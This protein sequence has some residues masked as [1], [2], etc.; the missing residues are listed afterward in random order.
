MSHAEQIPMQRLSAAAKLQAFL[1]SVHCRSLCT[2]PRMRAASLSRLGWKIFFQGLE[3]QLRRPAKPCTLS[4]SCAV[5]F[6]AGRVL[7]EKI[8]SKESRNE[9][10]SDL[11][12]P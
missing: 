9:G 2:L 7:D 11:R 5:R 3:K 10:Y 6:S 4:S 1:F 8:K 12:R